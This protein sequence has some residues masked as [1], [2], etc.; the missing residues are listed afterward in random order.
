MDRFTMAITMAT[1]GH[2]SFYHGQQDVHGNRAS[3]HG[4]FLAVAMATM[5]I[6]AWGAH[7]TH[8]NQFFSTIDPDFLTMISKILA[9]VYT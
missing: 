7:T 6:L 3:G 5:V 8:S 1:D 9:I 4:K 2:G